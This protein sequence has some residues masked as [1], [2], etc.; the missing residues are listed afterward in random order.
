MGTPMRGG[1]GP[2]LVGAPYLQSD[3]STWGTTNYYPNNTNPIIFTDSSFQVGG[4]KRSRARRRSK[5]SR[6]RSKR[7]RGRRS[8]SRRSRSKRSRGGRS[9]SR[10]KRS[11][12]V[13]QRSRRSRRVRQRGGGWFDNRYTTPLPQPVSNAVGAL[14]GGITNV[15]NGLRGNELAVSSNPTDQPIDQNPGPG[16]YDLTPPDVTQAFQDSDN[17]VASL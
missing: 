12:R 15:Y 4:R 6:G 7:S 11:R 10:S 1:M 9:R 13:R 14:T 2:A 16:A 5:R 3:P 17:S 8:R